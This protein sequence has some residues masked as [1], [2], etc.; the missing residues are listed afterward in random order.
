MKALWEHIWSKARPGDHIS[1]AVNTATTAGYKFMSFNGLVYFIA[2]GAPY[3]TGIT[4]ADL[5]K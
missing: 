3:D 1:Y 4:V 2:A 5:E